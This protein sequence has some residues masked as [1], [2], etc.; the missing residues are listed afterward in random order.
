MGA[1]GVWQA[2]LGNLAIACSLRACVQGKKECVWAFGAAGGAPRKCTYVYNLRDNKA[3]SDCM[4]SESE[5]VRGCFVYFTK[6][7]V[8]DG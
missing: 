3:L 5:C 6:G 1:Q 7:L 4:E 2:L 8:W